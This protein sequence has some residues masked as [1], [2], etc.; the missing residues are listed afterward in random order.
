LNHFQLR[1]L[2]VDVLL[3]IRVV[4]NQTNFPSIQNPAGTRVPARQF[5]DH[6]A[7]IANCVELGGRK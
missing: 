5:L 2:Y 3:L 6:S 4:R 1:K 7:F